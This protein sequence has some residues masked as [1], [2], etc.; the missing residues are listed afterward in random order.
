MNEFPARNPEFRQ[1]VADHVAA[2]GYL[3]L[4]GVEL[5]GV[6]PGRAEYRVRF[7]PDLGQQDG[8]FHGGVIGGIAEGVMG[9]AA[10]TLVEA[11][12]NVVGAEYKCNLL[13][14]ASGSLL[15]A[16][17]IVVRAGGRLIVCR[18]DV[19]SRDD[20]GKETLAAIAQGTMAVVRPR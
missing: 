11:G 1:A 5:A 8:V 7:R 10:F 20:A 6:A 12:A 4:L 19:L 18:A 14:S 9:A 17:G 15:I 2:Q 13:A 3:A 16:R